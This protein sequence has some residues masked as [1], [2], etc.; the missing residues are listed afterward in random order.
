MNGT[1][2]AAAELDLLLPRIA[3]S[4]R[5]PALV[6]RVA[7]DGH[8]RSAGHDPAA[9]AAGDHA[10][11]ESSRAAH[12]NDAHDTEHGNGAHEDA[13]E[14]VYEDHAHRDDAHDGEREDGAGADAGDRDVTFALDTHLSS[15]GIARAVTSSLLHRWHVTALADDVTT[16][17]SEL[18]TNALRHGTPLVPREWVILLRLI[19]YLDTVMCVVADPNTIAP[20]VREPDYVAETGRGMHVVQCYSRRWGWMPRPCG[21]G[22]IVWAVFW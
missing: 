6:T 8:V 20:V 13:H 12:E 18:V 1:A 10:P 19:K 22:K 9:V 16:V 7:R 21:Q 17:V 11:A 5:R 14:D 4:M 2:G 15:V 3:D